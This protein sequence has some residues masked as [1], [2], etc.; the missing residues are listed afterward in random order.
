M[1]SILIRV[2]DKIGA[3]SLILSMCQNVVPNP[4]LKYS[5]ENPMY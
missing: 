3:F 4:F 1:K 2:V 5:N